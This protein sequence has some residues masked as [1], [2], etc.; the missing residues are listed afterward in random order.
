MT[1][2]SLFSG[3]GG[4][5]LGL[6]RAGMECRFQVEIDPFCRKVLAKHWP[7]VKRYGDI[8]K[9]TGDELEPVDL[10]CGGFPCQDVSNAGKA[11][12]Y[13]LG[14]DGERS[15]LWREFNRIAGILEPRWLVIENVGA[16][17]VRG[18]QDVLW[19]ITAGGFD[20]D[21]S[22]ISAGSL[23]AP[24]IRKR[25][26]I[27]GRRRIRFASELP[28]CEEGC[29]ELWCPECGAHYFECDHPGPDNWEE[30]ISD[31]NGSGLEGNECFLL[32]QPQDRRQNPDS[33]RS[34]WRYPSPRIYRRTDGLPHWMD[35]IK[36]IGNAVD[37]RVAEWIGR[38]ILLD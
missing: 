1:F 31:A 33:L 21:W 7:E 32:A 2:G 14:L 12:G 28:E 13:C 8:T 6:E 11:H 35:R 26:F 23:G 27:V 10:L 18:L 36:A 29:G 20:S 38:R 37:P 17:T 9:L 15:G 19:D 24:H 34:D 25:L 16:I 5:D 22:V 4:L 3:V 30:A